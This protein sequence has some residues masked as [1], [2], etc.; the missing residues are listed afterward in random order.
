MLLSGRFSAPESVT[1]RLCLCLASGGLRARAAGNSL[2]PLALPQPR[3]AHLPAS[4]REQARVP[5]QTVAHRQADSPSSPHRAHRHWKAQL[6][7]EP[8][9]KTVKVCLP[10]R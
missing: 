5:R 9:Q 10:W 3:R 1:L 8:G 2:W 4:S 7:G 6:A